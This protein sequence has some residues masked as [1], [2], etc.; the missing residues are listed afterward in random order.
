MQ[1]GCLWLRPGSHTEP[2]RRQMI[3]NPAYFGLDE[4]SAKTQHAESPPQMIFK[5]HAGASNSV[6]T[7]D[8]AMPPGSWPPP[9]NGLFDAGFLPAECDA[10]DLLIFAGVHVH[11][12]LRQSRE[13]ESQSC[14]VPF[15]GELDHLS[16]PNFSDTPRHTF[17]L[18]AIEG[19]DA[20]ITWS[21]ANWLQYPRGAHFTKLSGA[22]VNVAQ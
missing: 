18:H 10:G 1:N 21:P 12:H 17:Q 19:T 9:C 13:S 6:A 2:V 22:P 5:E 7:W 20:G 8:G 14:C 11:T 3:R 16:L 15:A 4:K